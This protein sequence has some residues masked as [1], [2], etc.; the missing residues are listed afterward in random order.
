M[1][2]PGRTV[3]KVSAQATLEELMVRRYP[4]GAA[5]QLE[6][7]AWVPQ[8]DA[9]RELGVNIFR[10]GVL[11]SNDHLEAAETDAR[12]MG[13]SR[14]SLDVELRWRREAPVVRRW[15]RP[16]RDILNWF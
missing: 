2:L 3:P 11:I 1:V 9:A 14:G 10:I 8:H 12:E 15:L 5:V 6:A 16:L 4:E 13:V 7:P